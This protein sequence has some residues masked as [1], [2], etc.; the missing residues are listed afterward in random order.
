MMTV[1]EILDVCLTPEERGRWIVNYIEHNSLERLFEFLKEGVSSYHPLLSTKSFWW[2]E[3]SE[4]CD[5]WIWILYKIKK[6]Y[7]SYVRGIAPRMKPLKK[8][9]L[10]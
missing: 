2:N 7:E 6:K 9:K 3:T 1:D 4:G 5:Y 8:V 10:T